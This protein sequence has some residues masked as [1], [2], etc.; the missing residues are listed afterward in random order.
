MVL[1]VAAYSVYVGYAILFL[2][3]R[4]LSNA[5]AGLT[6]TLSSIAV[7]ILQPLA[8]QFIE[9]NKRFHINYILAGIG[10][11]TFVFTILLIFVDHP[12]IL[13]L[14]MYVAATST[15]LLVMPLLSAMA[16]QFENSGIP[17]NYG[18]GRGSGSLGYAVSGYMIGFFV[19]RYDPNL[20]PQFFAL[21]MALIVIA[22]LIHPKPPREEKNEN[23]RKKP[24]KPAIGTFALLKK[25]KPLLFFSISMACFGFVMVS[26]DYFQINVVQKIGGTTQEYGLVLFI[27][28]ASEIPT[29]F[30]FK[31]FMAR[32]KVSTLMNL[33]FLGLIAKVILLL[34][35][36][37]MGV[38]IGAQLLNALTL[39]LFSPALVYY[40]NEITKPEE[41]VVAQSISGGIAISVGRIFGGA[42][43]GILIDTGGVAA[44][45]LFC[46]GMSSI[47]LCLMRIA[48]Y[49]NL[50]RQSVRISAKG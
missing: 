10:L 40:T 18:I 23:E 24:T 44:M 15:S 13:V 33:A 39:G 30:L 16:M 20:I 9:R 37:N 46:M 6:M 45:L 2:Q 29:M 26:L 11:F 35:A 49:K 34:I 12:P 17:V 14:V 32:I 7:I 38:V 5:Q 1:Y 41:S 28:A 31:K 43:G 50:K 27:M 3:T 19:E 8:S 25:N 48:E 47:G 4:G 42:I 36:P 22:L 21:Y